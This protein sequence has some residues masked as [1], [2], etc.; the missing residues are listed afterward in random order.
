MREL[1]CEYDSHHHNL[2]LKWDIWFGMEPE[3]VGH[4]NCAYEAVHFMES[5]LAKNYGVLWL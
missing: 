4:A 5:L 2:I 3:Q 1:A